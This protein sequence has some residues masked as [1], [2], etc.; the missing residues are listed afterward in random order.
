MTRE[1]IRR[2]LDIRLAAKSAG[3]FLYEIAEKLGV[4]EPTFNRMLR[5]EMDEPTKRKALAAI[6]TILCEREIEQ[7][8]ISATAEL[9]G[10]GDEE[11]FCMAEKN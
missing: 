11:T 4:Y 6:E 7:Q 3:V 9:F 10:Y 2:N 1:I 8:N 5:K